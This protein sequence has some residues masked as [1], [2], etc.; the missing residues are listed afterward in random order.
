MDVL[1]QPPCNERSPW[2]RNATPWIL[3]P[4]V[5]WLV[6]RRHPRWRLLPVAV[7]LFSIAYTW[8]NDWAYVQLGLGGSVIHV[9]GLLV[10]FV[11]AAAL[12]P[13]TAA[14]RLGIF[15]VMVGGHLVL[16][17]ALPQARP[18]ASRLSTDAAL[19]VFV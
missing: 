8:G 13:A 17:M 7:V 14:G 5:A 16:D 3:L 18:L 1:S 15:A 4:T 6:L 12:L 10:C 11:T 2:S 9:L 19:F